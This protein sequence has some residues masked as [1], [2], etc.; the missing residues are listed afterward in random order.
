MVSILEKSRAPSRIEFRKGLEWGDGDQFGTSRR[1]PAEEVVPASDDQEQ[2]D[3]HQRDVE[4][5][6]VVHRL[7][8]HEPSDHVADDETDTQ[9]GEIHLQP[10]QGTA[11]S[12]ALLPRRLSVSCDPDNDTNIA[13]LCLKVKFTWFASRSLSAFSAD[14]ATNLYSIL[15]AKTNLRFRI[16]GEENF[17]I[18]R[19]KKREAPEM[20]FFCCP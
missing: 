6:P 3:A 8:A 19:V 1:L 14:S 10:P 13:Y 16:L 9:H 15:G 12:T 5:T 20:V 2:A 4:T 7:L 18:Q 17:L 11:F